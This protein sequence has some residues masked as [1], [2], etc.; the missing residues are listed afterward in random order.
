MLV[1]TNG[2][3]LLAFMVKRDLEIFE[4]FLGDL[5]LCGDCF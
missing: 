1:L 2:F 5:D 4:G 3:D